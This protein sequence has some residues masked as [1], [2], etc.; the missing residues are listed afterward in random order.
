MT[1]KELQN[2]LRQE[3]FDVKNAKVYVAV[4]GQRFNIEDVSIFD[5]EVHV[6][7][8]EPEEDE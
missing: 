2:K 4:Q 8:G 5:N 6:T 1:V 3:K 7:V